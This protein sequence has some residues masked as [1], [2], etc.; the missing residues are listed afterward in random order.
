MG[1]IEKDLLYTITILQVI[2]LI[3]LNIVTLRKVRFLKVKLKE[4]LNTFQDLRSTKKKM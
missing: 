2:I 1:I 3:I 4:K